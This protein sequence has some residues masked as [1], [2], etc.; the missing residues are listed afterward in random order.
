MITEISQS[1]G[2]AV[3][4]VVGAFLGQALAYMRETSDEPPRERVKIEFFVNSAGRR[5]G[6]IGFSLVS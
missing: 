2:E 6:W 5:V 4:V 3:G 1:Y